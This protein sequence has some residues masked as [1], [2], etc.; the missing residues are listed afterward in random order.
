MGEYKASFKREVGDMKQMFDQNVVFIK[1]ISILF[2][3]IVQKV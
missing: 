3:T 1:Q 2:R